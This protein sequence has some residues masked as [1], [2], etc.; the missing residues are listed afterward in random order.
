[1][2]VIE[3][4]L[5]ISACSSKFYSEGKMMVIEP[6]LRIRCMQFKIL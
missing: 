2:M 1:M 6:K 4:K 3:P 5:R